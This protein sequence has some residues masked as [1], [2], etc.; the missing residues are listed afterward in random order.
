M[1]KVKSLLHLIGTP[2]P[3]KV[4]ALAASEEAAASGPWP[5]E[6]APDADAEK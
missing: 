5:A 1:T 2:A 3:N 6:A 4:A